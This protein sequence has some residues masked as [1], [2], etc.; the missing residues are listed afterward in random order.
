[1]C[2]RVGLKREFKGL[3]QV[4]IWKDETWTHVQAYD[5]WGGA[6]GGFFSF[7]AHKKAAPGEGCGFEEGRSG[8]SRV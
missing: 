6:D 5:G 7:W 8:G 4:V 1:M 2:F 3:G